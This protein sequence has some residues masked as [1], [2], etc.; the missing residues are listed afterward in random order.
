MKKG[1]LTVSACPFCGSSAIRRVKGNW[2][3]NFR[4]KSYTVRAL[5]YFACPKCQEKIYP[6][7]AMR[8]IQKRSPAY[9]R[10]RPTRRAS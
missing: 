9:S 6:P 8:R 1:K 10:P 7:E 5:E 4:G 2:T 3:G